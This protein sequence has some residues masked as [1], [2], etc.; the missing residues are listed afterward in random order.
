MVEPR[1]VEVNALT[2][3]EAKLVGTPRSPSTLVKPFVKSDPAVPE[4]IPFVK[5]DSR[6]VP[7]E[8]MPEAEFVVD[9]A[10]A[11][12]SADVPPSLVV[13]AG[14]C[15]GNTTACCDVVA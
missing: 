5:S 8:P 2:M 12:V 11:A 1:P 13:G 4:P 15:W 14:V 3:G 9:W 6:S 10:A 7:N